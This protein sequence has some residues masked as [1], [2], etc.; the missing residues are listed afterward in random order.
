[1]LFLDVVVVVEVFMDSSGVL[2]VD[3]VVVGVIYLLFWYNCG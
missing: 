3:V 2:D 1:M